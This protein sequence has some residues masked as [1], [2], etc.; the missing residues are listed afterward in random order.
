MKTL[1]FKPEYEQKLK[2]LR[3]KTKFCKRLNAGRIYKES[4]DETAA[5]VNNQPSWLLFILGAFDFFTLSKEESKFWADIS[6]K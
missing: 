4:L 6:D 2:S 5:Y 3:I 1:I